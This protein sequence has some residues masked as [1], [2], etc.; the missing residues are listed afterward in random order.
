M[1][2]P[3]IEDIDIT[4]DILYSNLNYQLRTPFT[5]TNRSDHTYVFKV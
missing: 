1:N 4:Q 3:K 5:I 2:R